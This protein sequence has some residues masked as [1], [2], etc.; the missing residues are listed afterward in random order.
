MVGDFDTASTLK[1]VV[2][3][4]DIGGLVEAMMRWICGR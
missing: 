1:R 2:V 3:K 4:V